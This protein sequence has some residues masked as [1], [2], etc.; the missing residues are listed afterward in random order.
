ME[1]TVLRE[2]HIAPGEVMI[3]YKEALRYTGYRDSA[4][5]EEFARRGEEIVG[6][7]KRLI[8]PKACYRRVSI[9]RPREDVLCLGNLCMESH[10][11]Y[12]T[13]EGCSSAYLFAATVGVGVEREIHKAAHRSPVEEVLTDA[14][15]SAAIE[16]LCDRIC[17][18]FAG[19]EAPRKLTM[20]FSPG[21]GDLSIATQ[22]D[23][24]R[25]LDT[26]RKIGM[27]LT[28]GM[29][30]SPT[31]SV[32]AI[33]GVKDEI[34]AGDSLP[35]VDGEHPKI[36]EE[37]FDTSHHNCAACTAVDCIYRAEGR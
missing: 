16:G 34:V 4:P 26:H 5:N 30:M 7:M 32:S 8:T 9:E 17:D 19:W 13:L 28:E 36:S 37:S 20:R 11:L 23:L 6:S 35:G 29:M 18:I 15:G 21:Y 14:A 1:N 27:S 31:K 33:V 25:N 3:S 2:L 24:I 10:N 12:K 22:K